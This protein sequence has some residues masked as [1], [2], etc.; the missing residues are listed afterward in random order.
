MQVLKNDLT[1]RLFGNL[2]VAHSAMITALL[3]F[4]SQLVALF[5]SMQDLCVCVCVF[6][7]HSPPPPSIYR[8]PSSGRFFLYKAMHSFAYFSGTMSL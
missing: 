5:Y 7:F 6:N 8:R 2:G 4:L 1:L 3:S